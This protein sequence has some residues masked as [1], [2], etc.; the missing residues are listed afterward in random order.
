[1]LFDALAFEFREVRIKKDARCPVCGTAP[2]IFA[3]IDYEAFCAG[4]APVAAEK[5]ALPTITVEEFSA[6]CSETDAPALL[7]VRNPHEYEIACVSGAI[8][9]PLGDL[10]SRLQEL[11]PSRQYV[12]TCHKGARAERAYHLLK[13]SGFERLQLLQGGIDAWAERID[14]S[15]ARYG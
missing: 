13:E 8:L 15:M 4:P 1:V 10:P 12:V 5:P 11:D 6:C 3:P 2:S 7:D 14:P 9:I